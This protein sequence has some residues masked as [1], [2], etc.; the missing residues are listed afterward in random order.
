MGN[1]VPF[2]MMIGMLPK[3][4]KVVPSGDW[5]NKLSSEFLSCYFI[6]QCIF[7]TLKKCTKNQMCCFS[8]DWSLHWLVIIVIVWNL[9][10]NTLM[11]M[12]CDFI[13]RCLL[14]CLTG[15]KNG[16][17]KINIFISL[18]VCVAVCPCYWLSRAV[19]FRLSLCSLVCWCVYRCSSVSVSTSGWLAHCLFICLF[20]LSISLSA[21]LGVSLFYRYLFYV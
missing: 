20:V 1:R 11:G 15:C 14:K 2:R 17:L 4:F 9:F 7:V 16:F 18:H 12:M 13:Q 19:A 5:R 8:N 6:L 3:C 21:W 10:E